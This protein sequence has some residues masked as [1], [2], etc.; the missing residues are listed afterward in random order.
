M[1]ART[2]LPPRGVA[3]VTVVAADL[4]TADVDATAAFARGADA[5][6]WLR[7]RPGSR[8]ARRLGG[9]PDRGGLTCRPGQ[10][11]AATSGPP[12]I[13]RGSGGP[14]M[15]LASATTSMASMML[16]RLMISAP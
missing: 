7:S 3:S 8:R 6:A 5:L 11:C 1:D 2:G 14:P 10:A 4:V 15:G 16:R 12:G 9:R 13:R